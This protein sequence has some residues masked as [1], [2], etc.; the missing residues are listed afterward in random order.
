MVVAAI[1]PG[2]AVPLHSHID[3]EDFIVISGEVQALRQDTQG[4]EWTAAKAG[5]YLHVPNGA[6]HGWSNASSE[7]FV[8]FIITTARLA[9]IL[10]RGGKTSG[11]TPQPGTAEDLAHSRPYPRNMVT[12][13]RLPKKSLRSGFSCSCVSVRST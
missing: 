7:P 1:P 6:R 12:R 3:P 9:K 13:T 10:S 4:Y 5:D 2:V 8:T 11:G